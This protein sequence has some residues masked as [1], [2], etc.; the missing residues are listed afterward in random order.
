[1]FL[2][3]DGNVATMFVATSGEED[4]QIGRVVSTGI[5]QIGTK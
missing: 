3:I 2:R 1:M 4:W 5:P